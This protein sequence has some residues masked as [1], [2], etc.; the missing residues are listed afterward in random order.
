VALPATRIIASERRFLETGQFSLTSECV[1]SHG[2]TKRIASANRELCSD[3]R[4]KRRRQRS[5]LI[6]HQSSIVSAISRHCLHFGR[7]NG[8]PRAGVDFL[9]SCSY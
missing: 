2:G 7:S 1:K 6:K 9:R 4:A 3:L 8:T 5:D